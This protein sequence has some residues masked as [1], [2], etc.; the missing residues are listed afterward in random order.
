MKII[1]TSP[2]HGARW[3]W[4]KMDLEE[5]VRLAC[6]NK[7]YMPNIG[8]LHIPNLQDWTVELGDA[9]NSKRLWINSLV[10]AHACLEL[11]NTKNQAALKQFA[12]NLLVKYFRQYDSDKGIFT[13]A[14][15]DEHAVANRLFVITAFLHDTCCNADDKYISQLELLYHAERHAEWLLNDAHYVQNNH[16][17]MM[18]LALAQFAVFIGGVD[19]EA[20][21]RYLAK[22]LRR[23]E[24]MLDSTFD[25][26][27]CCTENSPT[28]HF[29]NYALFSSIEQF[30]RQ[31]SLIAN[32]DKWVEVLRKAKYVGRLFLRADGTIPLVGD[33]ECRP[34]TF[35]P[36]DEAEAIEGGGRIFP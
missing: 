18:D 24:M 19:S 3:P 26:E 2:L 9:A 5:V 22:A 27:G 35:F 29:V 30:I 21:E 33:S 14:W 17:V 28:Y 4:P 6:E 8:Y 13:A 1:N 12:K 15:K 31:Y 20:S 32:T 25:S 34:G 10:S 16:G 36:H 7:L 11:S 23:L